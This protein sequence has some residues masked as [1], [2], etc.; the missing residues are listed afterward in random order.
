MD[1]SRFSS[2]LVFFVGNYF[3]FHHRLSRGGDL[4]REK[5]EASANQRSERS[6]I[7][8]LPAF[9]RRHKQS[10]QLRLSRVPRGIGFEDDAGAGAPSRRRPTA[11]GRA[12]SVYH[13]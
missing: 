5:A 13:A 7:F 6:I 12:V 1:D 10:D 11:R 4:A 2:P 9:R 8:V 3:V